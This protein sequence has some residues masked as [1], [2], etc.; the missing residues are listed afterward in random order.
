MRI[1]ET[2]AYAYMHYGREVTHGHRNKLSVH[3]YGK[4]GWYMRNVMG[5]YGHNF[6]DFLETVASSS[7]IMVDGRNSNSDTGELLFKKSSPGVEIARARENAAWKDVEHDR[8]VVL[9]KG[10]M[11]VIDRCASDTEHVYDWLY[12]ANYTGLS[13]DTSRSYEAAPKTF[14]DSPLY[15]GLAP[16]AKFPAVGAADWLRVDGSGVRMASIKLGEMFQFHVK[17]ATKPSDGILWRQKGKS[18]VFAAA[19]WPY[20]KGEAGEVAIEKLAEGAFRVTAPEG[21]YTVLVNY[22]GGKFAAGGFETSEPVAV[23]VTEG[24]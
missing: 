6:K 9:T 18:C 8:T 2:D 7:T 22:A 13:L 19:F 10:P 12:H 11:I 21:K 20:R 1:P 14:G 5:G 4:G 3:A 15:S 17:D 16:V 23:F 24:K